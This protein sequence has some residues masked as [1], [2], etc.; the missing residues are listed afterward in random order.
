MAALARPAGIPVHASVGLALPVLV[1]GLLVGLLPPLFGAALVFG[2]IVL[3]I[4]IARPLLPLYVL[5]LAAPLGSVRE[6]RAGGIGLSPTEA[7]VVL[8]LLSY[9]LALL[10]RREADGKLSLWSIPTALFVGVAVLSLSWAPDLVAGVKEVLRWVELAAAFGLVVTLVRSEAQARLLLTIVLV[11]GL[12]EG[13]LGAAQFL[14]RIGPPGFLIGRFLRAYG[15]FGQPNPYGGYLAM[16]LPVALAVAWTFLFGWLR[17]APWRDQ[18]RLSTTSLRPL[19]WPLFAGLVLVVVAA[20]L[21]MSLSR[22][23]WL[24][25]VVGLAAAMM[26]AGRKTM[27]AVLLG[28]L[29]VVLVAL[30]GAFDVLPATVAERLSLISQYFGVFDVRSV[31]LS[32]ENWPIVERMGHWQTAWEMWLDHPW[33]GV[34]AGQYPVLYPDYMMPGWAD[35]LGHAHNIYL[36]VAAEMGGVGLAVYLLMVGSWLVLALRVVRRSARPLARAIGLGVLGVVV[37]SA[38]HNLFDNLYVAGMNVHVGVLI[39]LVAA[40]PHLRHPARLGPG[41]SAA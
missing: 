37:A 10:A 17:T 15:T 8:A 2:A 11:G 21:A 7:L 9:G 38:T 40:A 13:L 23:A 29:V 5:G 19:A 33:L 4:G 36:N 39:G 3:V 20:G 30:M 35:P 18:A 34:G 22:G 28:L 1:A 25:V 6:I 14:L 16:V 41:E 27:A 32:S 26:A 31:V 24:G 12:A